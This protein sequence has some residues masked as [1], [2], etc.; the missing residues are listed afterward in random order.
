M[1]FLF[2]IFSSPDNQLVIFDVIVFPLAAFVLFRD[3]SRKN[4][5]LN[6]T[7]PISDFSKMRLRTTENAC[8]GPHA[9]RGP[10]IGP[11]CPLSLKKYSRRYG[12]PCT[13]AFSHE[14]FLIHRV[15]CRTH[16]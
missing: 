1:K 9:A 5:R 15:E 13:V 12:S 8:G 16:F 10:V 3:L 6:H 4:A 14:R 11:H 2:Y 7:I